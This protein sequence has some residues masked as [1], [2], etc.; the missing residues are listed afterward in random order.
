MWSGKML[1]T[2][3]GL[4]D[5]KA[6]RMMAALREGRT[7]RTFGVRPPRLQAYFESHPEYAREA[8]PLIEANDKAARLRKGARLR[9]RTHCKYGHPFSGGNLFFY[10]GRVATLSDLHCEKPCRKPHDV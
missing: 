5:E 2:P 7:L 10:S 9:N 8:L 1:G 3:K 4:S 6:A